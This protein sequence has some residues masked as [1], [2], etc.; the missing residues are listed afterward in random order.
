MR[1]EEA[2]MSAATGKPILYSKWFSSCSHRVRIALNLKG[3]DFEY[4]AT[5]PMTDPG[6][7][8]NLCSFF[9]FTMKSSLARR[10]PFLMAN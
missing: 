10:V 8:L 5:N 7:Q 3:V 6:I 9:F 4:R 2:A 1:K